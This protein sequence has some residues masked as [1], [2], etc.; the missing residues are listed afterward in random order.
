MKVI[1]RQSIETLGKAG[2]VV[3]V[4]SGYAINYLIPRQYAY[5]ALK[6]NL[7]AVQ[8]ER[9]QLEL[10]E[11][12]EIHSAQKIA[13]ELDKVQ[14][15]I[16]V[17]V[18]EEDKLFGSVTSQMIADALK[19]KEFDIDK[20]KIELDTQIKTLGIYDVTV[21]LHPKVNSTVKVWVV[22]E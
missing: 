1:L 22:R 11:Q 4:R 6:G 14:V 19:E 7:R 13:N 2:D 3:E 9:K 20:R 10:K 8:V 17:Q 16:P 15:T 12:K 21:K 18:G 5:A